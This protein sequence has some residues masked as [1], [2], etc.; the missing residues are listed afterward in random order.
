MQCLVAAVRPLQ[1]KELAE[2]LAFNFDAEGIPKL[3]SHWRW[4]DQEGA[5]ML[6]CSSLV[7]IVKDGDSRIVQFS[8]FSVKEF[9]TADRLA[10]PMRDVSRYHIEL[11]AAHT[12]L[13]QACIAVILRLDDHVDRDNIKDFPLAPYAAEYW[14]RH[15]K[16][17]SVSA[18]IKDEME[19]LFDEDKPHFA[20]WL[21]IYDENYGRRMSTMC[22][23]KPGAVPLYH[24]A[25]LGFSDLA[26]HLIAEHP[27]H[28]NARGDMGDTALHAAAKRRNTDI[29]SLLL[30]HDAGVDSRDEMDATS[31]HWASYSG[32]LSAGKCLLDHGA[33]INARDQNGL[34]PLFDAARKGHVE[35]AQI[36]LERG[37]VIDARDNRGRT[38]LYMAAVWGKTQ[39]AR[40]LLE[41]SADVNARDKSGKTPSQYVMQQEILELLSGYGAESVK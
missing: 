25:R 24:A 27:E 8:H 31:L 35:F 10:E 14:P 11:E 13:A 23:E 2:V 30:E 12:I 38:S 1:V 22:P 4:E 37:A 20:T 6:A 17:G 39:V 26:A 3:N 32:A 36:L 28:V 40:L 33:D 21:W 34:I 9:L 41:H 16:F 18:R 29:L 5:V 19:Y 7:T 15:A